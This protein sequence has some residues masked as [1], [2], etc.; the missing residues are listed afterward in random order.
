[1]DHFLTF[2]PKCKEDII[3]YAKLVK[4]FRVYELLNGLNPEY[5]QLRVI[6]LGKDSL[7][8]LMKCMEFSIEKRNTAVL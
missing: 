4:E 6:I 1:M 8:L 3:V 5:K 2:R 7:P